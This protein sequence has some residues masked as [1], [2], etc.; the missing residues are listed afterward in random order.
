MPSFGFTVIEVSLTVSIWPRTK[1]CTLGRVGFSVLQRRPLTSSAAFVFVPLPIAPPV[2]PPVF[3]N[4]PERLPK[5]A[6][7]PRPAWPRTQPSS[8]PSE[9]TAEK[10]ACVRSSAPAIV[11][12]P[13]TQPSFFVAL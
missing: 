12:R 13:S 6:P 10:P 2:S 7:S 5:S 11:R 4:E 9:L 3:E 1:R 8:L